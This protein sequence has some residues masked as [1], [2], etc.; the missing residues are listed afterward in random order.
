MNIRWMAVLTGF[1]VDLVSSTLLFAIAFPQIIFS[2]Q[3]MDMNDPLAIGI[4]LLGTAIGGYV[5][6]RMGQAQRILHGLLVGVVGILMLQIQVALDGDALSRIAVLA[7]AAGCL[8]GALG[9]AL[10]R[11]PPERKQSP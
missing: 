11:Y 5:A 10:S 8:A 2:S 9:G 1:I 3:S 4:G 6:G 7:L